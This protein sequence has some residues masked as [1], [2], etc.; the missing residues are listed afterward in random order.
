MINP[1]RPHSSTPDDFPSME[2]GQ[3]ARKERS[4]EAI[5]RTRSLIR[6]IL[7][8]GMKK[9]EGARAV[10]ISLRNSEEKIKALM[11]QL[12]LQMGEGEVSK[13]LKVYQQGAADREFHMHKEAYE[14]IDQIK[15]DAGPVARI[16]KPQLLETVTV[17]NDLA[18]SLLGMGVK[19]EVGQELDVIIMDEIKGVDLATYLY[20]EV[21]KR[22]PD[23]QDLCTPETRHK[24]PADRLVE[25]MDFFELSDRVGQALGFARLK[26]PGGD[27]AQFREQRLQKEN[28][29]KLMD[30]LR[31]KG[32]R[33]P[34]GVMDAVENTVRQLH[35]A[36]LYHRDLHERNIMLGD[37][38][39][40][41]MIDFDT[42]IN[43][44][45]SD[46]YH[47]AD[48][49]EYID[50][51][52]LVGM[53]RGLSQ[54]HEDIVRQKTADV[55]DGLE[56]Y[57]SRLLERGGGN[58]QQLVA[59]WR[60]FEHDMEAGR[61]TTTANEI[62]EGVSSLYHRDQQLA[63]LAIHKMLQGIPNEKRREIIAELTHL[64]PLDFYNKYV[65]HFV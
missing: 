25:P 27:E 43:T 8:R 20:N 31:R 48:G 32:I 44:R 24:S 12:N 1:E 21:V 63:A 15:D 28:A 11:E 10:I 29:Q 14:I 5:E 55:L 58:K 13:L 4:P 6:D 7:L 47:R 37:D 41:W 2:N 34:A 50:D 19:R 39:R 57:K 23:L 51:M 30:F 56:S 62:A 16:P 59:L 38:G 40:V 42:A 22:H 18:H 52:M 64:Y 36:D 45:E 9:N 17:T 3:V 46:P 61:I 65:K 54:S 53:Y 49:S 33:L 60:E 35:Q 26:N